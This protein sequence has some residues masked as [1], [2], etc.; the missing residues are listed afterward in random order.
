VSYCEF[1]GNVTGELITNIH[2]HNN[3]NVT[4]VTVPSRKNACTQPSS[5]CT[6]VTMMLRQMC[7]SRLLV[8]GLILVT[9]IGKELIRHVDETGYNGKA[10]PFILIY[11]YT[12][13]ISL[14]S[15]HV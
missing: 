3:K 1:N 4:K 13:R 9:K 5:Y 11:I 7:Q 12:T 14:A 15:K 10:T 6:L 8:Y 2:G